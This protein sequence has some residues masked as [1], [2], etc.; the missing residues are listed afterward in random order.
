MNENYSVN[1]TA[2]PKSTRTKLA[3]AF[4][5]LFTVGTA[6]IGGLLSI[7]GFAAAD[8]ARRG[9]G[10]IGCGDGVP[11]PAGAR[12]AVVFAIIVA[13]GTVLIVGGIQKALANSR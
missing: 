12:Q 5:H 10:F 8:C 11:D 2:I 9:A 13:V 6:L 7:L 4:L 1:M 3:R